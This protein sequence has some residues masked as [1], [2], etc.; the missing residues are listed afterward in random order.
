ML[1][2]LLTCLPIISLDSQTIH[3]QKMY[4]YEFFPNRGYTTMGAVGQ[5][6]DL[7]KSNVKKIEILPYHD[8][9]KFKWKELGFKY[10][11]ENV[12]VATSEDLDRA[13]KILGIN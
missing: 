10:P 6:L 8:M 11:L 5:F 13:K 3:T 2:V 1:L 7:E 12:R 9:G 4:L